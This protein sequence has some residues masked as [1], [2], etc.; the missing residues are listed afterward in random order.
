MR[1]YCFSNI[2]GGDQAWHLLAATT[3]ALYLARTTYCQREACNRPT[4][5]SAPSKCSDRHHFSYVLTSQGDSESWQ[6]NSFC[7]LKVYPSV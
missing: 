5:P 1:S 2:A 6:H 7:A 3:F 4:R